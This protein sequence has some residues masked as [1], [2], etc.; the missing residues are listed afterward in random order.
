MSDNSIQQQLNPSVALGL[1]SSQA[2]T[3]SMMGN[4]LQ[5]MQS[6]ATT[7]NAINQNKLFQQEFGAKQAMGPIAQEAIKGA[8]DAQGNVDHSKM[9]D[10]ML[11]GAA[12]DPRAAFKVPELAGQIIQ[13]KL[14]ESG[15]TKNQVESSLKLNEALGTG[16]AGLF[17]PGSQFD[18]KSIHE[19]IGNQGKMLPNP[20][21]QAQWTKGALEQIRLLP[22]QPESTG[23]AGL[24][25]VK[26]E[27]WRQEVRNAASPLMAHNQ[28][29]VQNLN[30]A[31]RT[32]E[33]VDTGDK[34]V[35]VVRNQRTGALEQPEPP[36]GSGMTGDALQGKTAFTKGVT[37]DTK[38]T[39]AK[40][41]VV[42]ADPDTGA[43]VNTTLDQLPEY[44]EGRP[45][46]A[47]PAPR[48]APSNVSLSDAEQANRKA[49]V[50]GFVK[51][52][53]NLAAQ[54][55]DSQQALKRMEDIKKTLDSA[56][57]LKTGPAA[58]AMAEAGKAL[59]VLGV[60]DEVFNRWL[61]TDVA[62]AQIVAKL[63][64]SGAMTG[65]R[66]DIAGGSGGR[67]GQMEFMRYLDAYPSIEL[68]REAINA[69]FGFAKTQYSLDVDKQKMLNHF[70]SMPDTV[71]GK[72]G[73]SEFSEA[74]SRRY[75]EHIERLYGKGDEK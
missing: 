65:L 56:K 73:L 16:M 25:K 11:S 59:S 1:A 45:G 66:S 17:A 72:R 7:Q 43:K 49:V 67:I 63:Q 32:F 13:R 18:M 52:Q 48:G 26:M 57:T 19:L 21:D 20:A 40:K 31:Y 22:K 39:T 64:T 74:W 54:L 44:G 3:Q 55:K 61:K 33:N 46:V 68:K 30:L 27:M 28:Q 53:D 8:T 24:D 9:L 15:I 69:L 23:D 34:I 75:G 51:E 4:P 71:Q 41:E 5:A 14:A 37:P 58:A 62:A 36:A 6:L 42:R 38:L 2:P 35:P 47:S 50:E 70:R 29:T 10:S 12:R 60:P